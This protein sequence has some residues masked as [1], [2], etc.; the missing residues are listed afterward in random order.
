MPLLLLV[1]GFANALMPVS[2]MDHNK[3]SKPAKKRVKLENRFGLLNCHS[4][5]QNNGLVR[6]CAVNDDQSPLRTYLS[7][8]IANLYLRSLRCVITLKLAWCLYFL[9]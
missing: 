6:S 3:P 2:G 4:D 8:I 9:V 1:F 5:R 7:D